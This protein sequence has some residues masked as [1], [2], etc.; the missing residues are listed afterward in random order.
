MWALFWLRQKHKLRGAD[1]CID[2]QA[3][4]VAKAL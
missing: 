2:V 3:R 4:C 1:D